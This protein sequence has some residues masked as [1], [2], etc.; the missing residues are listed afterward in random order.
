MEKFGDDDAKG[1]S[2]RDSDG[3]LGVV[4]DTAFAE[5]LSEGGRG[6]RKENGEGESG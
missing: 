5:G 6:E 2:W 3:A 1:F 4:F